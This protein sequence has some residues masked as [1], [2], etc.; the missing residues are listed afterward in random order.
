MV[1]TFSKAKRSEIM[2]ANRGHGNRSTEMRLCTLLTASGVTGWRVHA[3]DIIGKPDFVF[4]TEKLAIFVD[5]CFWHGCSKCRV[6][7][8]TN[9]EFWEAK[10]KATIARDKRVTRRLRYLGWHVIRIW[11]HELKRRP[12]ATVDRIVRKLTESIQKQ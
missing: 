3:T 5:G 11:E 7:P 6:L 8:K 1:D 4:D 10:I 2:A 12:S 9:Q